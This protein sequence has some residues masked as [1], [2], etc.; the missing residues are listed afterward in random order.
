MTHHDWKEQLAPFF[1]AFAEAKAQ[2]DPNHVLTP[3]QGIF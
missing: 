1:G 2:F 3:G